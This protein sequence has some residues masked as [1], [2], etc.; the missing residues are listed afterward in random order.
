MVGTT[1]GPVVGDEELRMPKYT[2]FSSS[3]VNSRFDLNFRV[4]SVAR[5]RFE[6]DEN[7]CGILRFSE[8]FCKVNS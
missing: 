3:S 7:S 1:E 6:C 5:P 2:S 4:I 8:Y